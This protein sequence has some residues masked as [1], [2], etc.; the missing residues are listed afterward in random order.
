M[1]SSNSPTVKLSEAAARRVTF[2]KAR[3]GREPLYLR[4]EVQG[5][6]CSGFSYR[7]DLADQLEEND[8]LFEAHGVA[9]VIDEASL[10]FLQGAEIDYLEEMI[11]A[12]F[13]VNNPNA[14]AA[15]G[16]GSSFSVF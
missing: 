1:L 3:D 12:A 10:E 16:C 7:F 5:G 14:T 9:Y 13:K 6:G 4:L 11:G 2:L 15:C 8:K